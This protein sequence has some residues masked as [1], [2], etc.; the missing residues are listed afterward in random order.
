MNRELLCINV[1]L[2]LC[3]VEFPDVLSFSGPLHNPISSDNGKETPEK[4]L[5]IIMGSIVAVVVCLAIVI[6]MVIIFLKR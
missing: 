1:V 3:D 4:P 2:L 6:I 5:P